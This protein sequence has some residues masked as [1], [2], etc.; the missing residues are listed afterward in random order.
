MKITICDDCLSDMLHTERLLQQYSTEHPLMHCEVKKYSDSGLLYQRIKQGEY[1]D[2]YILDIVMSPKNGIELGRLISKVQREAVISFTTSSREYAMEAYEVFA[3]RYL[4]KPYTKK[5][6]WEM[7]DY[8]QMLVGSREVKK[9]SVKTKEGVVSIAHTKIL[10]VECAARM[11][12]IHLT[13]KKVVNSIFIRKSF[14]SEVENLLQNREFQ[15]VHKSFLV[16]MAHIQV[17]AQEKIIMTDGAVIPVSQKRAAQVKHN[18]LNYIADRSR[19]GSM[20]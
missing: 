1:A 4:V 10:Y 6:M 3:Q 11:L 19:E 20:E 2:I 18:Y 8:A 14:E 9:Y 17:F 15:Q 7:L 13:D 16:N 12:H 5:E